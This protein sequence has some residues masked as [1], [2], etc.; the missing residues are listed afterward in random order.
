MNWKTIQLILLGLGLASCGPESVSTGPRQTPTAIPPSGAGFLSTADP[1]M[2]KWMDERFEAEYRNM[3]P[4]LIFQQEP[5]SEL[6]C[7]LRGLPVGAPLFHY[8]STNI[9]RRELLQAIARFYDLEM[10]FQ[11]SAGQITHLLVEGP[12]VRHPSATVPS[13]PKPVVDDSP[14]PT[15]APVL[16]PSQESVLLP[17]GT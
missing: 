6:K 11:G 3:T 4:E 10:T 9:S 13:A 1:V 2:A 7:D 15:P 12:G 8:A 5:I 16:D 17:P 14:I